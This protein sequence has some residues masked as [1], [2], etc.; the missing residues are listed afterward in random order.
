MKTIFTSLFFALTILTVVAQDS[1]NISKHLIFKGV[2][3]DGPLDKYVSK[4]K[5]NGFTHLGTEDGTAVLKGEFAGYK[6]CTVGV[7]TLKQKDL[8]HKIAVIFPE[9]KTWSSLYG[10]YFNLQEMLTGKYGTP[11]DVIEKF[12]SYSQPRDDNSK[13]Y[14]VKFDRCKYYTVYETE[15]GT[16]ELSIEHDD[17][18]SCFVKLLYFDK[19]NN[20]IVKEKA[21]DD[22]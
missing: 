4:M 18:G 15:K 3:I 17:E 21:K 9:H 10:N 19:I 1:S 6:Y 11:S 7:S 2:P 12:D 22:L 13:I 14:E 8:V 20:D 5:L 16:L